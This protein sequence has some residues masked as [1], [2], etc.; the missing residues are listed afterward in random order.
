[1]GAALAGLA[2]MAVKM[3]VAVEFLA[4]LKNWRS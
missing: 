2:G 4:R 3:A 1:M